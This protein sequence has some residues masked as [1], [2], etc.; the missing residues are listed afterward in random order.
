LAEAESPTAERSRP[1]ARE[2]ILEAA[3]GIA[4][5]LGPAHVTLEA[6]AER[7][8]ISKGG[9]LYHFPT[10]HALLVALL[11]RHLA[12]TDA[13]LGAAETAE[14]GTGGVAAAFVAAYRREYCDKR[15]PQPG[16]IL[17]VL[18]E[19]P[20][21]LDPVREHNRRLL[22]RIRRTAAEPELALI[23]F[24]AV[25]GLRALDLFET[26]PVSA[27]ERERTLDRLSALLAEAG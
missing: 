12:E 24:L 27:E 7:A 26:N 18:A 25:E 6:V 16:G 23:A 17:P 4:K 2:R 19:N 21:L 20:S 13:V 10:K 15:M 14:A 11:E 5:D 1:V 22:E 3:I 9:L 8:A